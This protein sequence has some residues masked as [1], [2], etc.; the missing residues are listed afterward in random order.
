MKDNIIKIKLFL[1]KEPEG[2][3]QPNG[4]IGTQ[5]TRDYYV[6]F[7]LNKESRL[8]G[9]YVDIQFDPTR[10]DMQRQLINPWFIEFGFFE[11]L[12]T[13]GITG[14]TSNNYN[15]A[16]PISQNLIKKANILSIDIY[17]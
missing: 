11:S 16:V 4:F 5:N 7:P 1:Q 2:V 9:D 14:K 6:N 13:T 3:V 17:R 8:L 10:F 15:V 12:T